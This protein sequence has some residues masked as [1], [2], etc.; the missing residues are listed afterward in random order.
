[1]N[2]KVIVLPGTETPL[3]EGGATLQNELINKARESQSVLG[4][5]RTHQTSLIPFSVMATFVV[6][7]LCGTHSWGW[8]SPQTQ[9]MPWAQVAR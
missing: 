4:I 5:K 1:M 6:C 7:Y 2:R 8:T 3:S 9:I